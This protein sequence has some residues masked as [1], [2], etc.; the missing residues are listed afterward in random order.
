MAQSFLIFDFGPEEQPAQA[1][2]HKL[3]LWRQAF[4]LNKKL[5]YKFERLSAG[6]R[7]ARENSEKPTKKK[8]AEAAQKAQPAAEPP[9]DIRVTVRLSFSD[10]ER[11]SHHRWLERIPGEEPFKGAAPKIVRQGEADFEATSEHFDSLD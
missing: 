6:D 2:R 7:Q 3:E 11:L 5:E 1:A 10:H 9:E 8:G 4:H